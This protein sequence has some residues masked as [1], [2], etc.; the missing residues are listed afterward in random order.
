MKKFTLFSDHDGSLL[1]QQPGASRR[2]ILLGPSFDAVLKV[3]KIEQE[4]ERT[5]VEV[6]LE[7]MLETAVRST[8]T[9]AR[10]MGHDAMMQSA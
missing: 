5:F 7:N 10:N 3:L 9:T 8:D 4:R 6:L 1:R 2:T